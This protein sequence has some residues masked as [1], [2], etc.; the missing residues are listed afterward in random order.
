MFQIG[1][2]FSIAFPGPHPEHR[3]VSVGGSAMAEQTVKVTAGFD[4]E[5]RVWFVEES[6]LHGLNVEGATLEALIEKLPGAV[7]D[8]LE[9]EAAG[10]FG[11]ETGDVPIEVVARAETHAH[12][13][14]IR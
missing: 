6:N 14:G 1:D 8:L 7:V 13:G 9:V 2:S 11:L 12:L 3:F 4:R 5:A 10:E